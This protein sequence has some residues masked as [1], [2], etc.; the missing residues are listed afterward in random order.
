MLKHVYLKELGREGM[1]A[2]RLQKQPMGTTK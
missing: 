1:E 2:W